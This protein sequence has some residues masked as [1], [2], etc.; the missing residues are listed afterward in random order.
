[1]IEDSIQLI[2]NICVHLGPTYIVIIVQIIE[3]ISSFRLVLP[4]NWSKLPRKY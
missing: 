3:L 2:L 4:Q 1:M